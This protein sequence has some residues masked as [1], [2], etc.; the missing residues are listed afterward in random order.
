ME[1]VRDAR[2]YT[3]SPLDHAGGRAALGS[4]NPDQPSWLVPVN[5]TDS[6]GC[7]Q[8]RPAVGSPVHSGRPLGE[9]A[10]E[11]QVEDE[12]RT[13]G[14][15]WVRGRGGGGIQALR[16]RHRREGQS[17]GG[18]GREKRGPRQTRA[19]GHDP[20]RDSPQG[21]SGRPGGRDVEQTLK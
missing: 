8:P 2:R 14:P 4:H 7:V 17:D 1:S 16:S 21:A 13:G 11:G 18:A 5:S 20:G 6:E 12:H 3:I 15:R 19:G 9:G 10:R